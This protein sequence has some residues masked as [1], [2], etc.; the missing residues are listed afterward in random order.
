[1]ASLLATPIFD[2]CQEAPTAEAKLFIQTSG[3]PCET[4]PRTCQREPPPLR[5]PERGIGSQTAASFSRAASD[6]AATGSSKPTNGSSKATNGPSN[7]SL[8]QGEGEAHRAIPLQE[9]QYPSFQEARLQ[10]GRRTENWKG[11][12]RTAKR[13]KGRTKRNSE[14]KRM[15]TGSGTGVGKAGMMTAAATTVA[16]AMTRPRTILGDILD[17]RDGN[18]GKN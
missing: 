18:L 17:L 2:L 13:R 7:G 9:L 1:M 4:Q 14:R 16:V 3:V 5:G 8:G 10:Q 12:E 15:M 6:S 11:T